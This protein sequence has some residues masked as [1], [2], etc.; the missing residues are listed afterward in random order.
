MYEYDVLD[1]LFLFLLLRIGL[2]IPLGLP[3]LNYQIIIKKNLFESRKLMCE[4]L[5]DQSLLIAE[6]FKDKFIVLNYLFGLC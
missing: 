1:V 2:L 5:M 3:L 6:P 4:F